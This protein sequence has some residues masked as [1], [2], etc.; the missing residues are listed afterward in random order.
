MDIIT[1]RIGDLNCRMLGSQTPERVAILCHGYGA[2]GTDLVGL[3]PA[4]LEREPAL[5]DTLF[6]FPAAPLSLGG[7]AFFESRAWWELD[8]AAIERAM[9]RGEFREFRTELPDGLAAARHGLLA[10]VEEILRTTGLGMDRL[11]LGGFSQGAMLATD[12]T[13]RLEEAP[14]GLC[15]LSGTLLCENEWSSRASMRTQ[16]PILQSHGRQDPILPFQGA[17]WL[18]EML[19]GA[20]MTV[21]FHPFDGPHTIPESVLTATA[22]FIARC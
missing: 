5:H 12:L 2:P 20:G 6:V 19:E 16:L 13:L 14:A 11:V 3:G 21:E 15:V 17:V 4:M 22:R 1:T 9:A 18:Q 10:V 8:V 7:P